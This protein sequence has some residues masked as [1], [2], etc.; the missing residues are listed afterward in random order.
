MPR[1]VARSLRLAGVMGL[2]V[3]SSGGPWSRGLVLLMDVMGM[4]LLDSLEDSLGLVCLLENRVDV[5]QVDSIEHPVGGSRY[6]SSVEEV[7]IR[8]H[9]AF[10]L[11]ITLI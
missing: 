1:L 4:L 3:V 10:E 6:S 7:H 2:V 8:V 5:R 9:F 11:L